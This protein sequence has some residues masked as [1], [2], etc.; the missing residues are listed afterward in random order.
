[1][2]NDP[3]GNESVRAQSRPRS[4]RFPVTGHISSC[5]LGSASL[6]KQPCLHASSHSKEPSPY[7]MDLWSCSTGIVH[8]GVFNP[9]FKAWTQQECDAHTLQMQ[10][11]HKCQHMRPRTQLLTLPRLAFLGSSTSKSMASNNEK[12]TE[13]PSSVPSLPRRPLPQSVLAFLPHTHLSFASLLPCSN[14]VTHS[15]CL[16]WTEATEGY[17]HGM[18][19][20]GIKITPIFSPPPA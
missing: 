5:T 2:T 15:S 19:H 9:N 18:I 1:M 6:S 11:I 8:T 7:L 10:P 4:F 16:D 3:E 20:L 17:W 14:P 12:R 13:S